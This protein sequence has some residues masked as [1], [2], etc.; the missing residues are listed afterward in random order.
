MELTNE[1]FI[2]TI[3]TLEQIY[4]NWKLPDEYVATWKSIL[5]LSISD[6][7]FPLAILD[8]MSNVT[9]PPKNPSEI[10]KHARSMVVKEYGSAITEA[11]ILINSSQ[12]AYYATGDFLTF[13][14]E[15]NVSFA[16]IIGTPPQEA[17]IID[18]I[19]KRSGSPSILILVYNECKDALKN[20]FTGS[21]GRGLEFLTM[22]IE[23]S[24]SEKAKSLAQEFLLSG[25]TDVK[26]VTMLLSNYH[27]RTLL[28]GGGEQEDY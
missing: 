11:S 8:W 27:P 17:Y 5:T 26:R 1:T 28:D 6:E 9:T 23:K 13:A 15:Y 12:D 7:F 3:D 24:W 4:L 20:Y 22:H 25:E 19:M 14:D 21:A 18:N 2:A 10:I 16:S